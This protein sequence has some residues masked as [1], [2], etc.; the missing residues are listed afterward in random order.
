MHPQRNS[1]LIDSIPNQIGPQRMRP[2]LGHRSLKTTTLYLRVSP[3]GL[4]NITSPLDM[5]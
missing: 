1:N 2:D 5:E 4:S 3:K